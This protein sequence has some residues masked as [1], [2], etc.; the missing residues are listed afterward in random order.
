MK[1]KMNEYKFYKDINAWAIIGEVVCGII[2]F[3]LLILGFCLPPIGIID[4][5]VIQ[6]VGEIFGFATIWMIPNTILA[7][8][9]IKLEHGNTKISVG[10]QKNDA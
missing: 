9:T 1:S 4:V 6:G 10:E 8:K 2:A 5:S 3:G 7:G